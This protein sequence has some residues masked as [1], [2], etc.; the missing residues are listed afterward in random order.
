MATL[1]FIV[2]VTVFLYNLLVMQERKKETEKAF[3]AAATLAHW[4]SP[5]RALLRSSSDMWLKTVPRLGESF[6]ELKGETYA[7]KREKRKT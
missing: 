5:T 1:T 7:P 6:F 2:I 3:S 4:R